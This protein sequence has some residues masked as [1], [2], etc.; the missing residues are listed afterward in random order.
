[1]GVMGGY[2]KGA[3]KLAF[4]KNFRATV[5]RKEVEDRTGLEMD[6][7]MGTKPEV[8]RQMK[9]VRLSRPDTELCPSR[10][11]SIAYVFSTE[12]PSG[13]RWSRFLD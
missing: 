9:L 11:V 10:S 6:A 7:G 5:N 8:Y 4:Y 12:Y 2:A 13:T 3:M 1:M